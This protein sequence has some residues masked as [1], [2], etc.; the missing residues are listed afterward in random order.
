MLKAVVAHHWK[1]FQMLFKRVKNIENRTVKFDV[2]GFIES[3]IV[4]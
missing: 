3:K 4:A 1:T 2:I